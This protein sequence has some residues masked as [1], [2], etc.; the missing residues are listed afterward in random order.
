MPSVA[1]QPTLTSIH[2][3][4]FKE[5]GNDADKSLRLKKDGETLYTHDK[6]S[7]TTVK[8]ALHMD[9][10]QSRVAA[11]E[12]KKQAGAEFVKQAID[13]EFGPGMGDKVFGQAGGILGHDLSGGVTRRDLGVLLETAKAQQ[14]AEG[15]VAKLVGMDLANG[16]AK[17]NRETVREAVAALKDP[18]IPTD[19]KFAIADVLKQTV[20]EAG[21]EA[22]DNLFCGGGI[23]SDTDLVHGFLDATD[24]HG[25][26]ILTTEECI[27]RMRAQLDHQIPKEDAASFLRYP[28][29]ATAVMSH[30]IFSAD[31]GKLA[32]LKAQIKDTL[33]SMPGTY[34]DGTPDEVKH[35]DTLEMV[36]RLD[37]M[38]G[39]TD[40]ATP[41][42]RAVFGEIRDA[43]D[44][45]EN[46]GQSGDD[47]LEST[48]FLR[49]L[50]AKTLMVEVRADLGLGAFDSN[51]HPSTNAV[52][53]FQK[54]ASDRDTFPP[55]RAYMQD[56]LPTYR[57]DGSGMSR[58]V[59]SMK[60][61]AA[62]HPTATL[63]DV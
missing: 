33:V 18:K 10:D 25:D 45:A 21:A 48:V 22:F 11:R 7:S 44:N 41:E 52:T 34:P 8:R 54:A 37:G 30:A 49:G 4:H 43:V 38:F 61:G 59:D 35:A 16:D 15:V 13:N 46:A 50:F 17:E 32:G 56:W 53:F 12:A 19:Q 6:L 27:D 58:M 57:D 60:A 55:N 51:T 5:T 29:T 47:F 28:S 36:D 1:N 39:D 40:L 14:D 63:Q 9:V 2:A 62:I 42:M 23:N 20:G 31:D 26:P 24:P 3:T